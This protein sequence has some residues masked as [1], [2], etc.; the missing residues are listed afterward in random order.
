MVNRSDRQR[1]GA[2]GTRPAAD[3]I[4]RAQSTRGTIKP[5]LGLPSGAP[6]ALVQGGIES[7]LFAYPS[8]AKCSLIPNCIPPPRTQ[9]CPRGFTLPRFLPFFSVLA[10]PFRHRHLLCQLRFVEIAV[11]IRGKSGNT[12]L[13][14][15][16]YSYN[17]YTNFSS[18]FFL[19][20]LLFVSLLENARYFF[21]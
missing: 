11:I 5:P 13:F 4:S 12:C 14:S 8:R 7:P 20:L 19:L 21:N 15:E 1:V 2:T 6:F 9:G 16:F 3:S 18:F 10:P 17:E